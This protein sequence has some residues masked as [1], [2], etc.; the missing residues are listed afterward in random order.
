MASITTWW[1]LEPQRAGDLQESLQARVHDPLWLLARQWQ[2]GEWQG[3]DAGSPVKAVLDARTAPLTAYHAGPLP[4]RGRVAGEPYDPG[5]VPLEAL[6]ER[7]QVRGRPAVGVVAGAGRTDLRLAAEAGLHFLRL[8]EAAGQGAVV[9]RVPAAFR[10]APPTAAERAAWDSASLRFAD[11]MAERAPDGDALYAALVAALRPPGPGTVVGVLVGADG[12]TDAVARAWLDWY[13]DLFAEPDG[14]VS[15]WIAERMEHRFAMAAG[16]PEGDLVLHAAEYADGDLDWYAFDVVP[17]AS[18]GAADNSTP[19]ATTV[20]PAPVRFR[21]MPSDRW[22]EMEDASVDFGG[23]EA[24][25]TDLARLLLVE[26]ALVYGNDWFVVPVDVPAGGTCAVTSFVVT[27]SFGEA[28]DVA[29][30]SAAAGGEPWRMFE[31]AVEGGSRSSRRKLAP[32]LF[33]PPTLV[34]TLS[35]S[36]VEDVLFLRDEMANMAWAVERIVEG[37]ANR[38]V[39]RRQLTAEVFTRA[40]ATALPAATARP[41]KPRCATACPPACP[42]TGCRSCPCRSAAAASAW[43]AAASWRAR[44]TSHPTAPSAGCSNRGGR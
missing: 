10:L 7:E 14:A 17:G 22:W 33:V 18:L 20:L 21:G 15:P 11:L 27:D 42:T 13:E 43:R 12:D 24:A 35:S 41:R 5:A 6:V 34:S 2:T 39:E 36:P 30:V 32:G 1:R 29:A 28:T 8:L 37:P 3:E 9:E 23:I 19:V 44:R 31:L 4:A 40:A 16:T 25:P 26:F 38:P